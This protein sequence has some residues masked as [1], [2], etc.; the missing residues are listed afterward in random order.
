MQSSSRQ[1]LWSASSQN[2]GLGVWA[3][4]GSPMAG[5]AIR[6]PTPPLSTAVEVRIQKSVELVAGAVSSQLHVATAC[7]LPCRLNPE[8]R[9]MLCTASAEQAPPTEAC[10]EGVQGSRRT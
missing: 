10:L 2:N 8:R 5:P 1:R 4:R 7:P 6:L 9:R 3:S